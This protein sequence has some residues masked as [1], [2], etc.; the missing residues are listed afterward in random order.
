MRTRSLTA[1]T[2]VAFAS[3]SLSGQAAPAAAPAMAPAMAPAPKV[4]FRAEFLGNMAMV[5][6][7]YIQLAEAI[8]ADKYTWRPAPGVR[9]I[10][11]VLL[12][13]ANAQYLFGTSMGWPAPAGWDMKTF[14]TSTTDKAKVI[15]AMKTAFTWYETG[16]MVMPDAAAENTGSFF[17]NKLTMRAFLFAETDHNAEHLG[18]LIAYS[19]MNGVVP[20][21]SMKAGG[22]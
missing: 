12:H 19:R 4:G 5:T 2:A 21:W 22:M 3:A 1:L 11:E 6:D 8:P 18:Q 16:V 17:G 14:E 7:K 10:A 9:S 20:P 15:A 13:I